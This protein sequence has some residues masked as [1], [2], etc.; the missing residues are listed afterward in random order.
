[1][2]KQIEYIVYCDAMDETD[3][4]I[5]KSAAVEAAKNLLK[6][7]SDYNNGPVDGIVVD[8]Y[9]LDSSVTMKVQA[10]YILKEEDFKHGIRK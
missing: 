2:D 10:K 5:G 4:V 8:I 3:T 7:Y 1:M 6:E 9:K